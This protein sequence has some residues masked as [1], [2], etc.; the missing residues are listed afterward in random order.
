MPQ[1]KLFVCSVSIGMMVWAETKEEAAAIASDKFDEEADHIML[2][3][4]D[5]IVS[6][7]GGGK[8]RIYAENWGDDDKPY[9]DHGELPRTVGECFE[10][11]EKRK[12]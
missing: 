12:P 3:P 7:A 6:D 8:R 2:D 10:E 4:E 5:F 1:K 11:I 9:D